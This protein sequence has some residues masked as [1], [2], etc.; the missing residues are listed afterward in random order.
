MRKAT[1][2]IT[3]GPTREYLDPVRYI[4]NASSGA[5]G[6]ALARAAQQAGHRVILISGPVAIE[7]PQGVT[8]C[9]VVSALDM[10]SMVKRHCKKADIVLGAAAVADY[11]PIKYCR[12]KIKKNSAKTPIKMLRLVENPDIITYAGAQKQRAAVVVGFALE[13]EH[14]LEQAHRKLKEK[15]LDL[16]VANTPSTINAEMAS[17]WIMSKDGA[18][19]ALLKKRKTLIA[20]RIVNETLTLWQSRT[21]GKKLHRR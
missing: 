21:V 9:P 13:T 1:F 20:Q 4:S 8:V 11:R 18:V 7:A 3:A 17:V 6:Y 19:T 16:I 15:H 2:L 10:F 14:M 12:H 5:M